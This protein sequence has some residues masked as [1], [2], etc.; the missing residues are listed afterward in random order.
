MRRNRKAF[1]IS[2]MAL[3]AAGLIIF[4]AIKVKNGFSDMQE[5]FNNDLPATYTIPEEDSTIIAKTYWSKLNAESIINFRQRF[6]I[7]ILTFDKIYYLIINK[8]QLNKDISLKEAIHKTD[9]NTDRTTG[10]VYSIF[11]LGYSRQF[12]YRSSVTGPIS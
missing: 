6:P 5:S 2:T 9:E 11:N 3:I 8:I 4:L 1:T 12:Q 7:S 10:E